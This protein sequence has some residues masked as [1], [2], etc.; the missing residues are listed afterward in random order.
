MMENRFKAALA[1]ERMLLGCWLNMG[2]AVAAEMAGLAGFDW[3]LIDGEHAPY[4]VAAI[5]DQLR[6]LAA[7]DTVPVLRVPVGETW[8]IK[9]A[10]DMGAQN[11]LVPMVDTAEQAA[12]LVADMR[13]PP[14]GRRGMGAAVSRVSGYGANAE[15][16]TEANQRVCL[17]V[18]AESRMALENLDAI[19]AT[20]GVD[21]VFIG[22]SD[23]AAD[24]GHTG[25]A[26][27]PEVQAA[28][29]DAIARIQA[30][31][32]AAGILDFNP[33]RYA[34]YRAA[35][36]SLL[37]VAADVSVLRGGLA[38]IAAAACVR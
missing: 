27:A 7:F 20:D 5:I 9:Q 8:I 31:G 32:K 14:A 18:Q 16:I 6:A 35:G 17:I 4:D 38:E 13:Y 11:L 26:N 29:K 37:A 33:E 15:Y 25:N 22:P 36:V 2:S 28:I 23:L 12:G 19:A 1:G 34:T 3:A 30:A 21:A 24:M 10:L